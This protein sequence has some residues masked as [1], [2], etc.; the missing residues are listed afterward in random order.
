MFSKLKNF[1]Q[2]IKVLLK[3]KYIFKKPKT[4]KTIIF[5]NKG[6]NTPYYKLFENNNCEILHV[7]GETLNIYVVLLMLLNLKAL[8]LKNYIEQYIRLLKPK[9]IFHN[10][11][12]IRFFELNNKDFEFNFEKIFTQSELKNHHDYNEFLNGKENLNCDYLF[13]WSKGMKKLM[14]KNIT[15]KYLIN[16]SFFNNEVPEINFNNLKNKLVFV[17][18]Y[19]TFKKYN[20]N[21]TKKTIRNEYHGLKFSWEQFYSADLDVADKLKKYCLKKNIMFEVI[22]SSIDDKENEKLF[23]ESRLGKDNWKFIESSQEKR[24]IF[25]TTTAR[26]IITIDSTL[27]YEC[28]SRGQRVGFFSVRPKYLKTNY[29]RFGWPLNLEEEGNC[30]TTNNSKEDFDRIMN[31]LINKDDIEWQKILNNE[32][33]DLV[34]YNQ[35][36]SMYKKFLK[37][38]NIINDTTN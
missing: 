17:S 13:V 10:S 35:K 26:Y 12:N 8:S 16:G 38:Q 23:F 21:D 30:W 34:F 32:L 4:K 29:A 11:F 6:A 33:K 3:T 22:G 15:G 31:F 18:Q 25:L 24:G 37:E 19:R 5:D 27:G 28:L 36:N 2:V 14:Q 1:F 7:Q 9:F 20:K